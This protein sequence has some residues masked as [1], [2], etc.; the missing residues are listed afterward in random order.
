MDFPCFRLAA[1]PRKTKRNRMK[2]IHFI[3]LRFFGLMYFKKPKASTSSKMCRHSAL[4]S[5][6]FNL[7]INFPPCGCPCFSSCKQEINTANGE[8]QTAS[9][10]SCLSCDRFS[11]PHRTTAQSVCMCELLSPEDIALLPWAPLC[12][13][14][15]SLAWDSRDKCNSS[16]SDARI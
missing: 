1:Q 7:K 11:T 16:T 13:A 8:R 14:A 12:T 15:P 9:R 4:I 10:M 2:R 3:S 6:N 5:F